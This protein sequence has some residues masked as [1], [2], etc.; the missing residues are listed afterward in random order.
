MP[1]QFFSRPEM[2]FL[3]EFFSV[4]NLY[5]V[6]AVLRGSWDFFCTISEQWLIEY[7]LYNIEALVRDMMSAKFSSG[8]LCIG[9]FQEVHQI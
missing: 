7:L 2:P 8:I 6:K 5:F 3:I 9:F 1:T 4:A